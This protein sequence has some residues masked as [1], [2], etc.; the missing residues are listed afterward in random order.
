MLTH[1]HNIMT[2]ESC[3]NPT[4]CKAYEGESCKASNNDDL[5]SDEHLTLCITLSVAYANLDNRSMEFDC[6]H[7][8][9][10][11]LMYKIY[12]MTFMTRD[13]TMAQRTVATSHEHY[14]SHLFQWSRSKN[15]TKDYA[16]FYHFSKRYPTMEF[17]QTFDRGER[18]PLIY[19]MISTDYRFNMLKHLAKQWMHDQL[20]SDTDSSTKIDLVGYCT[21]C[22][23]K[24]SEYRAH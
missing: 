11:F 21:S 19:K 15:F 13:E 5:F 9:L 23:Q 20:V 14:L 22:A 24:H 4:D 16:L 8:K 12:R 7:P 17:K 6:S 1:G 2:L 3:A 10:A 18:G